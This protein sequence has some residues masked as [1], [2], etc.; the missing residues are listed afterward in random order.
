M[1]ETACQIYAGY[2]TIKNEI[3][4]SYLH[5]EKFTAQIK[6]IIPIS[7]TECLLPI[8]TFSNKVSPTKAKKAKSLK[9]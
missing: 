8:K 6:S 2:M 4:K 5:V 7:V 9:G 3:N 1:H